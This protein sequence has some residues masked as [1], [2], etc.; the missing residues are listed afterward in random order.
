MVRTLND[1]GFAIKSRELHRVRTTHRWLLRSPAGSG[2]NDKPRR[3][4][5]NAEAVTSQSSGDALN[6]HNVSLGDDLLMSA[7][8]SSVNQYSCLIAEERRREMEAES[9]ERWITK[10]RRRRTRQYAGMP[11]DPPG[12]PRF[13]SETTLSQ[14][15]EILGLDKAS[16]ADVRQQFQS[17]CESVGIIKKSVAGPK[18]WEDAKN[19]L[20][21]RNEPLQTVFWIDKSN[22]EHKQLALDV[23]CSDVTKRMREGGDKPMLMT[24]AKNILDLDPE[25]TREVRSAFY[26]IL[27]ADGFTSKVALGPERWQH[28]KQKWV[29]ECD[30]LQK[31]LARLGNPRSF[32][33]KH[34]AVEALATDVMKRF[35]DDLSKRKD[36][37]ID[38][39]GAAVASLEN[40]GYTAHTGGIEQLQG[41]ASGYAEM[42]VPDQSQNIQPPRLL[43]EHLL[44]AQ[45]GMQ[46]PMDTGLGQPLLLDPNAQGGFMG[47]HQQFMSGPGPLSAGTS[48]FG[49][50]QATPFQSATPNNT[51]IPIY[52][53]ELNDAGSLGDLWIGFLSMPSPSLEE[54]RQVAA[55]KIPG[56]TCTGVEGLV[57]VPGMGGQSVG[58]PIQDDAQ[59]AAHLSQEGPC[60]F[61]VRLTNMYTG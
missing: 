57:K 7:R 9:T 16:Y 2:M 32:E 49:A 43:P 1:E 4:N 53:R 26:K 20:I 19:A 22:L 47:S 48:P 45:M 37:R 29:D 18:V 21:S 39:G 6:V 46:M 41:G 15:Q 40:L 17:I 61:H 5:G 25:K 12:P 50:S 23:L 60:T 33:L 11:A 24:D 42:L 54:L 34:K 51:L 56:S 28:L 30:T 35:R 44:D 59:L 38:N 10:K 27:E 55:Q 13:P 58:L 3:P 14:S 8:L 31:T 52:L 36:G